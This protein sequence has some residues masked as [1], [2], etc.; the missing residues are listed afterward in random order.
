MRYQKRG[1]EKML[2][3]SRTIT[4]FALVIA[5]LLAGAPV[6][7]AQQ[8]DKFPIGSYESGPYTITFKEGGKYEVTA[9]AGGGV[10]GIYK[11]SGND[12]EVTDQ[13]G[14]FACPDTVVGKYKWKVDGEKLV[15]TII[16]DACEGRAQGFSMPLAKKVAK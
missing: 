10:K 4:S 11:V 12:V 6:V 3:W 5:L 7:C 13:D 15:M 8:S 1:D 9:S 16:D 14:D 2:K